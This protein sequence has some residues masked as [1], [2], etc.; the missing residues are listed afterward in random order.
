VAQFLQKS[1]GNFCCG[2]ERK[3]RKGD[4]KWANE[5]SGFFRHYP[6][7]AA[8]SSG[9]VDGR[10]HLAWQMSES[11]NPLNAGDLVLFVMHGRR[12]AME[13]IAS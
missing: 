11:P 6:G 12:S 5:M 13:S 2:G 7:T 10:D 4:N 9:A 3:L 1:G 8:L